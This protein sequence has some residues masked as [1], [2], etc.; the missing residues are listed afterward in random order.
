[1]KPLTRKELDHLS[2]GGDV[3]RHAADLIEKG[4]CQYEYAVTAEGKTVRVLHP[5]AAKWCAMGA[6]EN[7]QDEYTTPPVA[8][9]K[10]AKAI[11]EAPAETAADTITLWNDAYGR[12][13]AEV[14]AKLWE[15]A[16]TVDDELR[17]GYDALHSPS[18]EHSAAQG[19]A[20]RTT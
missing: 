14:V 5:R 11:G 7:A 18:N 15:A 1:M 4:W 12:T 2:N 3:L 9:V 10:L 17:A 20:R 19:G 8:A 6:I 16:A 13:Q